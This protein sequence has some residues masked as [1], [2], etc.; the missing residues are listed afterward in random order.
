MPPGKR[1]REDYPSLYYSNRYISQQDG[2][3]DN[4]GDGFLQRKVNDINHA[5]SF[6]NPLNF[7]S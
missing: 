1:K 4:V 7:F 3:S 6:S 2:S 5:F